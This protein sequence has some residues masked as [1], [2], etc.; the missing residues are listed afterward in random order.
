MLF[1]SA[2]SSRFVFPNDWGMLFLCKGWGVVYMNW[3]VFNLLVQKNKSM[4]HSFLHIN[5]IMKK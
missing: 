3:G 2:V 4:I 1:K 5:H